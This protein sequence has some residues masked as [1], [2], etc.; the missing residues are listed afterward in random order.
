MI[1]NFFSR[2]G[3]VGTTVAAVAFAM[4]TQGEV[5]FIDAATNPDAMAVLGITSDECQV[6]DNLKYERLR[7]V[8]NDYL[9][10]L[11]GK[12]VID[13]GSTDP[14]VDGMNLLVTTS[15]YMSLKNTVVDA[16][17]VDYVVLREETGRAITA[18]DVAKTLGKK[19]V[20]AI[21]TDPAVARAVDA[22]LFATRLPS[23]M[24]LP[25]AMWTNVVAT[26]AVSNA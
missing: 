15:C 9:R 10:N 8:S 3:G 23:Q 5:T 13:W 17:P 1:Y 20:W 7:T 19:V 6:N 24:R 4:Q 26:A 18:S 14:L 25:S 2:K 16:P 21:P 12:I 11:T 22:G